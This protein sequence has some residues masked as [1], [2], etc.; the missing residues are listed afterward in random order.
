MRPCSTPWPW[1]RRPS[2]SAS[3]ELSK[4]LAHAEG[5]G[6]YHVLHR[7]ERSSPAHARNCGVA[8][9]RGDVI[10]FLDADDLFLED[11]IRT[12][13]DAMQDRSVQMVKTGVRLDDPVHPEWASRIAHSLVI[14]LAIRR[15]CHESVG[16]FFDYHLVRRFPDGY[17]DRGGDIF[18]MIEDVF[19]N[20]ILKTLYGRREIERETVAYRRNPGNSFDRQYAKF[21]SSPGSVVHEYDAE[22]GLRV[23]IAQLITNHHKA[24]LGRPSRGKRGADAV[25]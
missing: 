16:G 4:V 5:K 22:K 9:S 2:H 3:V 24:I 10:L 21:C 20:D 6:H 23:Q 1:R 18:F 13:N 11:H 19:Y 14:N 15:E 17:E 12:C 25:V 8:A 7:D